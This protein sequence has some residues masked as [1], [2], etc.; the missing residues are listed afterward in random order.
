MTT[1]EKHL[2][3][4]QL[5]TNVEMM[6]T[7]HMKLWIGEIFEAGAVSF[8]PDGTGTLNKEVREMV[9]ALHALLAGGTVEVAIVQKGGERC[10]RLERFFDQAW[11]ELN[12]VRK[13]QAQNSD[14]TKFDPLAP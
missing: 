7:E 4:V 8:A 10:D 11:E 3:D 14:T 1:S 5:K 13:L 9:E 12:E 2:D 6:V